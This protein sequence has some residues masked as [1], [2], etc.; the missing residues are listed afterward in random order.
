MGRILP[1]PEPVIGEKIRIC[2]GP[3]AGIEGVLTRVRSEFRVTVS[4]ELIRQSVSISVSPDEIVP[5]APTAVR[6]TI[7]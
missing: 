1:H 2:S 6:K 4:I 7:A 5:L 3:L